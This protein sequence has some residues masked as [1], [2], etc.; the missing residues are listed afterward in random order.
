MPENKKTVKTYKVTYN[1]DNCGSDN[2]ERDPVVLTSH[3][4]KFRYVCK[5]CG[6]QFIL[7]KSYPYI[8]YE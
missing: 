5:N 4:P 6:D 8:A 3:P 2:I 7:D 1:C